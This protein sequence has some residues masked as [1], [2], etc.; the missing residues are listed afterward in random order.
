MKVLNNRWGVGRCIIYILFLLFLCAADNPLKVHAGALEVEFYYDNACE[1]CKEDDKIYD[2]F[3]QCITKEEKEQTAYETAAYNIFQ[4]DNRSRFEKLCKENGVDSSKYNLPVCIVGDKWIWGY[5]NIEKELKAVF[6]NEGKSYPKESTS[7]EDDVNITQKSTQM[8]DEHNSEQKMKQETNSE[9]IA[10]LELIMNQELDAKEPFVLYFSTYSC[11]DCEKVKK[12]LEKIQSESG[13][14]IKEYNI[15]EKNYV[16][17]V[18]ELFVKYKV[19]EEEQRVPVVF[20][21]DSY[22]AGANRICDSLS[23]DIKEDKAE[24]GS[25]C[26]TMKTFI[27][28]GG[29]EA[30]GGKSFV[31]FIVSGFLAGFNP[32][33]ISMLL[34]LL[35]ILLT[36]NTSV[37]KSGF[38]YIAGKY[39][40]YFLIGTGI[41]FAASWISNGAFKTAGI[42]INLVIAGLFLVAAV[43]YFLDFWNVRKKEYGKIRMQLPKALRGFNHRLIK[44]AGTARP[45]LLMAVVFGLGVAISL[46]EFFCTGQIYMANVIYLLKTARESIGFVLLLFLAY[47]TAMCLPSMI[48]IY[49]IYKTKSVNRISDFMLNHMDMVKLFNALLFL[50]FAAYFLVLL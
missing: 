43:F 30:A 20:Y 50:A 12:E 38:L 35:S 45:V 39:V 7:A 25:I 15:A 31:M 42:V 29:T 8:A 4:T 18:Q 36:T 37:L 41:Y 48:F 11:K 46:G 26:Q 47:V 40:T 21:G 3:N 24:Y 9:I 27:S 17:L 32:C 28:E 16:Q 44:K 34:M 14:T 19:P 23:G 1:A 6:V 13:V 10:E 49:V 5:E 22:M 2:L 33:S